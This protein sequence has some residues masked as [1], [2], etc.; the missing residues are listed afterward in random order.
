MS[1]VQQAS[2]QLE[3][4]KVYLDVTLGKRFINYGTHSFTP[5][6][7]IA[8]SKHSSIGA[9][10]DYTRF[11]NFYNGDK[12]GYMNQYSYG[13]SYNYYSYFNQRNKGGGWG[14]FVNGSAAYTQT[15]QYIYETSTGLLSSDH[16]YKEVRLSVTPGIFFQPSK[17]IMMHASI[18]GG[19]LYKQHGEHGLQG[20]YDFGK[21]IDIGTTIKLSGLFK[22][23]K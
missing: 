16:V 9:F 1:F 2:A 13:I 14:W 4:G 21:R 10:F 22:K 12:W 23:K 18:G 20:K 3:K 17:R 19:T 5:S 11:K 7:S 8:I 6:A 15:D